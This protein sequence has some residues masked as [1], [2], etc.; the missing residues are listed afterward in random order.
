MTDATTKRILLTREQVVDAL[1]SEVDANGLSVTA[2][3]YGLSPQQVSDVSRGS[4]R[5]SERMWKKLRWR[6]F[7]LFEKIEELEASDELPT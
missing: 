5:L 2:R 7:E 6:R 1:R 4:A 3:K